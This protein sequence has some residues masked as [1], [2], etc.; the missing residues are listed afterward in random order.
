MYQTLPTCTGTAHAHWFSSCSYCCVWYPLQL[1]GY[2][3]VPIQLVGWLQY[4]F[5]SASI[6]VYTCVNSMSLLSQWAVETAAAAA[7][8]HAP[9]VSL[10]A[11]ST[12]PPDHDCN[13]H[14][15]AW[16]SDATSS[17]PQPADPVAKTPPV[18]STEAHT[19]DASPNLDLD[20]PC[21]S[22]TP[23][24]FIAPNMLDPPVPFPASLSVLPAPEQ[25][26]LREQRMR[27]PGQALYARWWRDRYA[28]IYSS[29]ALHQFSKLL[30]ADR[31]SFFEIVFTYIGTFRRI[32]CVYTVV[33]SHDIFHESPLLAPH[34]YFSEDGQEL[35]LFQLEGAAAW[36]AMHRRFELKLMPSL[37]L[38]TAKLM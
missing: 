26:R 22:H 20:S 19:H 8:R 2:A 24:P 25:Q 4:Q 14:S 36:N 9:A 6:E 30:L 17:A 18:S 15:C 32:K 16:P 11:P 29:S 23:P 3:Y 38:A 21:L 37:L 34:V 13:C 10:T 5:C 33:G 28:A 1:A 31:V 27:V 7:A 35:R 12:Q